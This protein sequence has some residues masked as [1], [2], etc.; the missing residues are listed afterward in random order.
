MSDVL[1][2][3]GYGWLSVFIFMSILWY[4]GKEIQNYAIVDVGWTVSLV[5]ICAVYFYLG[6]GWFERKLLIL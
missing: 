1:Q 3:V 6:N 5:L 4:I 2:I